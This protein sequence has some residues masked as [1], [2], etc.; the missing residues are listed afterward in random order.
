[1]AHW[2]T[3]LDKD[4]LGAWDLVD[5]RTNQARDFTLTI[6]R[7]ESKLLRTQ[8]KPNGQRKVTIWFDGAK[9]GFVAN[10]TNC[11]TIEG[12]YGGDVDGWTGKRITLY[13][14]TTSVGPR[15]DVPCV[16]VRPTIPKSKAE[17]LPEREVDHDQRAKQDEAFVRSV[18]GPADANDA[19]SKENP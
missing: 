18:S 11:T 14:T 13:P 8:S 16:R 5:P 9:K 17:T 6:S 4:Y 7:V 15:R 10:S 19:D 1:M 2:R 3:M 12:M